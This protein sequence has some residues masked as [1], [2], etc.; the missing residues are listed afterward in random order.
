MAFNI[1]D[2]G[3]DKFID[4]VDLYALLRLNDTSQDDLFI[5]AYAQDICLIVKAIFKKRAEHG[6]N[7]LENQLRLSEIDKNI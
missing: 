3:Q 6:M 7:N 5:K 1:Y 4:Q 2:L